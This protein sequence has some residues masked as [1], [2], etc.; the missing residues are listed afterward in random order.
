MVWPYKCLG[1]QLDEK[2]DWSQNTDLY[3]KIQN[4]LFFLRSLVSFN[5]CR[6]SVSLWCQCPLLF[7]D[8][9]VGEQHQEAGQPQIDEEGWLYGGC[10]A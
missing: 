8:V 7:C 10:E 4:R 9:L 2:L 5:P 3:G 6:G 1:L